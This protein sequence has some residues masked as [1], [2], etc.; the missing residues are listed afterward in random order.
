MYCLAEFQLPPP[1]HED[2]DL[3]P[4]NNPRSELTGLMHRACVIRHRFKQLEDQQQ[5]TLFNARSQ[6]NEDPIDPDQLLQEALELD[7]RLE[8]WYQRVEKTYTGGNPLRSIPINPQ[9]RPQWARELFSL[10]GAPKQ[11]HLYKSVLAALSAD[12]YRGTRLLLNL[13]ILQ[14]AR[15]SVVDSPIVDDKMALYNE[16]I[17][18]S[19]ASLMIELIGG[20]C[21]SVPC[22]LQLTA[23][24]GTDDPQTTEEL[25]GFRG[26]LL[27]WPFVCAATCLQDKDVQNCDADFKRAWIPCLF[28]FLRSSMSLAKAQAFMDKFV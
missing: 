4:K 3:F 15:R 18:A 16:S 6:L 19:T 22:M 8:E 28:A 20:L 2:M 25:Y 1:F 12:L 21:M 7:S 5:P 10:P 11:M 27:M 13:S 17:A 9:N 14:C 26:L 23:S 24:G